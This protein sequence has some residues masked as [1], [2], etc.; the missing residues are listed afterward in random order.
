MAMYIELEQ[1]AGERRRSGGDQKTG[2]K[3]ELDVLLDRHVAKRVDGRDA[4]QRTREIAKESLRKSFS[5]LYKEL[6]M[7]PLPHNLKEEHVRRLVRHW[8]FI[9]K[10]QVTTIGT[11]LSILRKLARWIGKP[12]LVK[13]L[14]VYL[15]EVDAELLMVPSPGGTSRAW[16]SAGINVEEKIGQAFAFDERFGLILLAQVAFGLSVNEALSL[17]PWRADNGTGLSIF[18]ADG[19]RHRR[20]RHI[21]YVI[22]EQKAVMNLIKHYMKKTQTL[23][24]EKTRRGKLS[25]LKSNKQEYYACM[26]VIGISKKSAGVVGDG[27]RAEF[28]LNMSAVNGFDPKTGY[29]HGQILS[30]V[31]STAPIVKTDELPEKKWRQVT[32]SYFRAFVRDV[33]GK[34]EYV[35]AAARGNQYRESEA[36]YAPESVGPRAMSDGA[37][38]ASGETR[39]Q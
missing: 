35:G 14:A 31:E 8:Y 18:S 24:W 3:T 17:Q 37:E 39:S 38:L 30:W 20:M 15:P 33:T 23:G 29:Y 6:G 27:L 28:A 26:E 22:P 4:E 1:D 32:A 9:Q 11:D 2:W 34:V 5:T 36:E 10:K 12:H 13:P 16:S 19:P 21:P 7:T 25:T